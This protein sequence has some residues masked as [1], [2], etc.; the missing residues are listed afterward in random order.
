M[1]GSE[2][3]AYDVGALLQQ[4][5][6]LFAAAKIG[7]EIFERLRQPAI[8]G[9][10]LAGVLVGPHVLGWVHPDEATFAMSELG[11][12]LLLFLVGLETK[13]RDLLSVGGIASAVAVGGVVVPFLLGYGTMHLLGEPFLVAL[14]VGTA[15]VATSVGITARVLGRMGLL[16]LRASRIILG[17]AILDDIL[18]LLVLAIVASFRAGAV[19]Y[20]QIGLTALSAITFTL[21]MLFFGGRVVQRTRPAVERLRIGHEFYIFAILL[22]LGLAVAA[23]RLGVAAIIGAFLAGMALSEVSEETG[24]HQR[25]E[26]LTE[27]FVPFFLAGIGTQLEV[28]SLAKP[29]VLALSV[30]ITLLAILGKVVG[31]GAPV[32]KQGRRQALQVGFGMVPRGEVGIVVAQLGLTQGVLNADLFAAVLF[33]A[34]ATTMIAP[35]VLTQLFASEVPVPHEPIVAVTTEPGPDRRALN[36]TECGLELE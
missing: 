33:V 30:G 22:C 13:P 29:S 4:L 32:W 6:I 19:D 26:G 11:V 36:D 28:A 3:S 12:L 9:E 2:T 21:F 25:F 16:H 35:P 31:C 8:V 14:F 20:R 23:G 34:V 24:L 5:F 27:F 7:A 10:I 17:A 15:L 18:G 1:H